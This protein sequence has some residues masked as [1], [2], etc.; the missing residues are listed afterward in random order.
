MTDSVGNETIEKY[1]CFFSRNWH[2]PDFLTW[3][4][5]KNIFGYAGYIYA[6]T[7]MN[8]WW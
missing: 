7:R 1:W 5:I 6:V 8:L 2:W 4:D 3:D